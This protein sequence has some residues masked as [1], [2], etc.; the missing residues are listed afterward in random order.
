MSNGEL[1]EVC[2][3]DFREQLKMDAYEEQLLRS[4]IDYAYEKMGLEDINISVHKLIADMESLG[5]YLE[6]SDV[7]EYLKELWWLT[8]NL[9]PLYG[10]A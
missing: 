10:D 5:Y 8:M 1:N 2:R 7:L 4:D 6:Y 3:E 9:K